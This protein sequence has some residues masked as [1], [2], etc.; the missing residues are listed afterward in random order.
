MRARYPVLIG[1]SAAL[2]LWAASGMQPVAAGVGNSSKSGVETRSLLGSYLAGRVARGQHDTETAATYYREALVRDPGNDVLIEQ[3]FLMELIEGNWARTEEL[4]RA[5][6]KA[7]P[8]HRTAHAFMGLIE[9]K[10]QRYEAADEHFKAANANPI[11]ELT[12]TLARAWLYRA[13]DK[14]Q[15]ALA[16][17]DAPKQP[18][19]WAQYYLRYHRALLADEA[20]RR[21][22][23]RAAYERIPKNDQRTLRV[24]LAY[25][26]HAANGGDAKLAQ[27]V[28]KAHFERTKNEGH[29]VAR[30]LQD[31]IDAGERP[32]L[33]VATP[34]AGLAEA[35]YG[36]GE[37]LTGEGGIGPGAVYLQFAL[38]L[39]SGSPFALAALANAYETTKRYEAAIAAYDRI[40][41]GTPL[42]A[43]VEIR[44]ALNLN[45]LERVDE[46]QKLL[47]QIAQE[48]PKDI[49]P[50]DALGSIMRGHK[51]FAEAVDYYTRAI[52]LID[53]PE[54]KHW[55]YFYSRGTSY[56][57]L[58]QWPLAE[59]DLQRAL[60]LS[61]DEALVLNYLGY[62][63]IDQN[64]NLKQG[65]ALIEKAVKQK[66]D[67]GYI[68]DSLGWAY[69][70]LGN[71]K[72]AVK[73][74]ERAV[75]LKPEDPV[76]NDH[77]GDSYWR[78]GRER[79][80][81]FQW[82]QALTLKPEPEDAEKIKKKLQKGLPAPPQA[83]TPKR[84]K[85]AQKRPEKG[86]KSSV[87]TQPTF[88]S[89][90]N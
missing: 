74:L 55:S 15:E 53:K 3:S 50:L 32:D 63:W 57:R 51:R 30:A 20:G 85:E 49:R 54:Q 31:Q 47:D 73:H 6:I 90:N 26:R 61:A 21:A 4:A 5:L 48:Y 77:L 37:A 14:T 69:F 41:K 62:S 23:A 72:E 70:R 60:Q 79:E 80:A 1:L 22:E 59:A 87:V 75:E 29:P 82:D 25:A 13:Q 46:A 16:V 33:L 52:A 17:L 78:V 40:P 68:V 28:L 11:G 58:K 38:Y 9:F 19:D 18:P 24:T 10:A 67:D 34:T 43:S 81:R 76:L 84:T 66:P 7:Q 8:T 36:L 45:Q 2:G 44:K 56:E 89:F 27:S 12:S 65:L 88:P 35:F 42:Q 86:K 71:F 39:D 64:R 83:R